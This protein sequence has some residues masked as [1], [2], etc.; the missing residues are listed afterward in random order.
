M[1]SLILLLPALGLAY[2]LYRFFVTFVLD[3]IRSPLGRLPGPPAPGWMTSHLRLILSPTSSPSIH[4][5]YMKAYGKSFRIRGFGYFDDRLVTLDP[6][7]ITHILSNVALYEKP[8]QSQRV[9]SNL[10]GNGLLSSEGMH[11]KKQRKV[12]NPAFSPQNMRRFVPIFNSKAIELKNRWL[13]LIDESKDVSTLDVAHWMN[14]ASFDVIGLTGFD[15]EFNAIENENN[16]VYLAYKNMFDVVINQNDQPLRSLATVLFPPIDWVM[17]SKAVKTVRQSHEIIYRV[18][19]ELLRRKKQEFL[20]GKADASATKDLLGLMIKSNLSNVPESQRITDQDVMDQINTF[21]FAGSDTTSLAMAWTL[22]LLAKNP[23]IQVRLREEITNALPETADQDVDLNAEYSTIDNLP[24]LDRVIRESLRVCP[25][26][27]SSMR[28]AL[29]DDLIPTSEPIKMKDGTTV[30]GIP[31]QKGQFVHVSFEAFN[32]DKSIWGEDAWEFKPD[33]WLNLPDAVSKQPGLWSNIMTFSAGPRSCI[34]M[35]FS[36]IEMKVFLS[37]LV[38]AFEF[39]I[40]PDLEIYAQNVV[41][42]RPYVRGQWSRG[43]QLPLLI[44]RHK[45]ATSS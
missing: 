11:H 33:R 1:P 7:A 18:S 13:R 4:E 44:T 23:D 22:H 29:K 5:K 40:V 32:L 36:I 21:F 45:R 34:G 28:C 30:A 6:R 37:V 24:F 43:T 10:I 15:Y 31:I 20:E 41:L 3:P 27:H 9:I 2:G 12:M 19:G 8:W 38:P 26:I 14:R 25:P 42:T 39:G 35:R 16:E 17:P